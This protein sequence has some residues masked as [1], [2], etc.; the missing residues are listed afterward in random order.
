MEKLQPFFLDIEFFL[1]EI[2]L[3]GCLFFFIEK[4]RPAQKET[5]F[6]KKDLKNEFL[7]ALVNI[8]I[9]QPIFGLTVIYLIVS[10]ISFVIPYQIFDETIQSWPFIVQIPLA[11]LIL[12]F[13]VY[14]RH[15]FTH[16]FM[17]S[18]H[19]VHHS[20]K[21]LTWLTSMRLHPV[22]ILIA[23]IFD[24]VVLHIFG[25][26]GVGI[27]GAFILIKLINYMTHM[28]MDLQFDKP[29]RYILASPNYHRWH[30][31][32]VRDAY[33]KNF[34]AALP[35]YDLLFGT[36]YHPETLPPNYGLSAIEQKNFPD[37]FAG[38]LSYPFKR[39]WKRLKKALKKN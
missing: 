35:L 11:I 32:T 1:A 2:V 14:W 30:H 22:D 20:A 33:D 9:F 4:L 31:A 13:A 3:F 16:Y 39:D 7:L 19:S 18:Y 26:G 10:L 21:E 25:F 23:M 36:Y 12:D 24:T 38:W 34:C 27:F 37:S 6:F 29:L 5:S 8:G 17:W 15:R 28:N